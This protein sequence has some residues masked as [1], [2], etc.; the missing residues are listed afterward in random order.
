MPLL[1]TA[2]QRAPHRR[3]SAC[4][5]T[6]GSARVLQSR[7]CCTPHART[8]GCRCAMSRCR[9]APCAVPRWTPLNVSALDMLQQCSP[10]H[11]PRSQ[12]RRRPPAGGLG[13]RG[14]GVRSH[15]PSRHMRECLPWRCHETKAVAQGGPERVLVLSGRCPHPAP[16]GAQRQVTRGP[17][18]RIVRPRLRQWSHAEA[19]VAHRVL[20]HLLPQARV[21]GMHATSH[22]RQLVDAAVQLRHARGARLRWHCHRCTE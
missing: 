8:C 7:M 12:R 1:A 4:A 9:C 19:G 14:T 5:P 15:D 11:M 13:G 10:H 22:T 3:R 17:H 2:R 21:V 6:P 18:A 20:P 16:P